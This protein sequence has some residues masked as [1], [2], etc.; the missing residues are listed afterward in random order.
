[1]IENLQEFFIG[2]RLSLRVQITKP[3]DLGKGILDYGTVISAEGAQYEGY[4]AAIRFNEDN[5]IQMT[6]D[7]GTLKL[8]DGRVFTG[9][10]TIPHKER[11]KYT[12]YEMV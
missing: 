11:W 8:P 3:G 5:L 9:D 6:L 1:M 10:F 2:N 12:Y 4:L 7:Y